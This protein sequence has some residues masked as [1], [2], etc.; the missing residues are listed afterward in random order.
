M[1]DEITAQHNNYLEHLKITSNDVFVTR[2]SQ[3][4]LRDAYENTATFVAIAKHIIGN[5]DTTSLF[6]RE[7]H[8]DLLSAHA[9]IAHGFTRPSHI[10][11]RC[12]MED[13]LYFIYY[14]DHPV[15]FAQWLEE[16]HS[17]QFI[18]L[19]SYLEKHP[20]ISD[21]KESIKLENLRTLYR[22]LSGTV[23]GSSQG[24]KTKDVITKD[25]IELSKWVGY[26]KKCIRAMVLIL[27]ILFQEK[28][29]GASFSHPKSVIGL[30]L[31]K[32]QKAFLRSKCKIAIP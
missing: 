5:E 11:L 22:R 10:A 1:K 25:S 9:L 29:Q 16:K 14:K 20:S 24:T 19:Y 30:I 8:A 31:S 21:H 23:H 26:Q 7:S 28:L 4:A 27:C 13:C 6:L 3:E 17:M 15:E 2:M 18:E 32:E 12:F